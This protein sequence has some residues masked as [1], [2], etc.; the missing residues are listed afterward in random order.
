MY[1]NIWNVDNVFIIDAKFVKGSETSAYDILGP[2]VLVA[3]RLLTPQPRHFHSEGL[4]IESHSFLSIVIFHARLINSEVV[5]RLRVIHKFV[6][7][8]FALSNGT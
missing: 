8:V 7:I 2:I 6:Q 4:R 5:F 3:V 1:R